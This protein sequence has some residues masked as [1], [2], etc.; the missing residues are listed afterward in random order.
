MD[1]FTFKAFGEEFLLVGYDY[2][3]VSLMAMANKEFLWSLPA[4]QSS[5]MRGM[6]K[7]VNTAPTTN[8][9]DREVTY[10]WVVYGA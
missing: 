1:L 7:L 8:Y 9:S 3:V 6:W 4:F 2:E 5:S 10:E